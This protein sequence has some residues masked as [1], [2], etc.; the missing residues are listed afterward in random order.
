MRRLRDWRF[1]FR[2]NACLARP[3]QTRSRATTAAGS[4]RIGWEHALDA[5]GAAAGPTGEPAPRPGNAV[6][7]L[8]DGA[9]GAADDAR[10]AAARRSRTFT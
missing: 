6:E 9:A 2:P 5:A 10:G 8:I 3:S 7:I 1:S 4:R